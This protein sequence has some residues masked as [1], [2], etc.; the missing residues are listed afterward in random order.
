M[1]V[2]IALSGCS[3]RYNDLPVFSVFPIENY[4]NQSVGRFK[5]SFIAEQ[6]EEFYQGV[7][8]GPIGVTTLVNIDDLYKSSTF[9]RLY[10]EQLM[11]ELSMR[12]FDVVELRHSD[13][14]QFLERDGEFALSRNTYAVRPSRELG[15][16]VVGTYAVSPDRVYVNVRLIEPSSSRVVSAGSV[17]MSKTS[18]LARLLK[19]G[20]AATTLE[21]I[22]IQRLGFGTSPM[23]GEAAIDPLER[24]D[25]VSEPP[26]LPAS[27]R[28]TSTRRK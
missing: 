13:A 3:K 4:E 11:S 7:D 20:G 5:T 22:P 9:G 23:L 8:P 2:C 18:E 27:P 16:L 26:R 19:K 10:S 25:F 14:I 24:E 21:R 15:G 17:E 6:I 28:A 12:G 1:G